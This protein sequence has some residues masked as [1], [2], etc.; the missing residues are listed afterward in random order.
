M[1]SQR[2]DGSR[3]S[4]ALPAFVAA[5]G[6]N[7]ESKAGVPPAVESNKSP[8]ANILVVDDNEMNLKL[9]TTVLSQLGYAVRAEKTGQEG[10]NAAFAGGFDLIL[11]DIQ[12]PD[13]SGIEAMKRIRATVQK[14]IPIVALTAYAMK[15][16]EQQL[17][18]EGFDD[19]IS[20]PIEIK[21][22]KNKLGNLLA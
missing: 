3:F 4:I 1:E 18:T 22:I 7:G 17:K 15:G 16:D 20:K 11:M 5:G 21:L 12:L 6:G 2:G 8:H 14:R 19:Y 10:V 13:M 9:I